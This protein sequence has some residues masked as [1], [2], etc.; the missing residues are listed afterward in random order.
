MEFAQFGEGTA[1][2]NPNS[3]LPSPWKVTKKI[4]PGRRRE[5]RDHELKRTV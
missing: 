4:E 1:I 5:D 2:G 3:N